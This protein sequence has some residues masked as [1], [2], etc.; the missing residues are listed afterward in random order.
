MYSINTFKLYCIHK[1][2]LYTKIPYIQENMYKTVYKHFT[3]PLV[4]KKQAYWKVNCP[5]N[6]TENVLCKIEVL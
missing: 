3:F 5:K 1:Y 6:M 2:V 4:V